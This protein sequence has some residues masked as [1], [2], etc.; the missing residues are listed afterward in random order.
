MVFEVSCLCNPP[1]I[2]CEGQVGLFVN[3]AQLVSDESVIKWNLG[4]KVNKDI[5]KIYGDVEGKQVRNR[6]YRRKVRNSKEIK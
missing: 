1:V 5:L 4:K 2:C 3:D 6:Y